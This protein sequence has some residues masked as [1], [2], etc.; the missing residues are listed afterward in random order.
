MY[1]NICAI[2]PFLAA[3]VSFINEKSFEG[4]QKSHYSLGLL[5]VPTPVN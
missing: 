1:S 4:A 2:L 3:L 5:G